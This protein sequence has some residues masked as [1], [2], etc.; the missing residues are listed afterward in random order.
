MYSA[1]NQFYGS[2]AGGGGGA[3]EQVN[4]TVNVTPG[5]T[6]TITIGK[7]NQNTTFGNLVTAR[8]NYGSMYN[9]AS[10]TNAVEYHYPGD[11][12]DGYGTAALA[13]N[14]SCGSWASYSVMYCSTTTYSFQGRAGKGYGAGGGGGFGNYTK[15]TLAN[16]TAGGAGAPGYM[17]IS[18]SVNKYKR[19]DDTIY[20]QE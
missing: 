1:A 12:G 7:S 8:Y 3:G 10:G 11:G 13:K 19:A 6:I 18:Y 4:Q 5:Q 16:N 20:I 9:G 14:G 15:N 2:G 17:Q